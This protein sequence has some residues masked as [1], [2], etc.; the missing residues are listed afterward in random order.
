MAHVVFAGVI[1]FS[2]FWGE[3]NLMLKCMVVFR[4]LFEVLVH[5][6]GWY[7]KDPFF[8]FTMANP[9]FCDVYT[10]DIHRIKGRL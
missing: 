1:Q 8:R 2:H 9:A 10:G 4:D 5:C 3:S 7:Y 6:L